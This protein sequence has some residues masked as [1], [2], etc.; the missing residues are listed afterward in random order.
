[1]ALEAL[2]EALERDALA[3]AGRRR[4]EARSGAEALIARAA[5][6]VDR[7]RAL[8]LA[9]L[10]SERRAQ[11]AREAAAASRQ[12]KGRVLTARAGVLGRVFG[13]ARRLLAG[14]D[15]AR[16]GSRLPALVEQTLSYLDPSDAVLECQPSAES[17]LR[18]VLA[19]RPGVRVQPRDDAGPGLLG[20][21]AD[22]RV[23]VDNILTARLDRLRD[24]LAIQL[25]ARLEG[26]PHAL[27]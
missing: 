12:L 17:A 11:V 2:L 13:E 19:D 23:V 22:G 5:A 4:T 18:K 14:L 16:W 21:S 15:Q 20:R 9:R 3:E 8:T 7:R 1:M 26:E 24:D 6:E 10:A 27:G 25:I